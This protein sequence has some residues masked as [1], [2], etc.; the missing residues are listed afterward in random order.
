[1]VLNKQFVKTNIL[2]IL[3]SM[4]AIV[5][6]VLMYLK[7]STLLDTV[8][9]YIFICTSIFVAVL[10]ISKSIKTGSHILLY[11]ALGFS[12]LALGNAYFTLLN[13][14][15][16][17]PDGI[18]VG[19][20]S[21]MCSYL[22]FLSVL[23][24]LK[25]DQKNKLKLFFT[26]VIIVSVIATIAC[27]VAV[28][29]NIVLIMLISI[30]LLDSLCIIVSATLVS[31][32]SAR[33]FALMMLITASLDFI[34]TLVSYNLIVIFISAMSPLLY[35]LLAKALITLKAGEKHA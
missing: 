32:K 1:M 29:T 4:W 34:A 8:N 11:G 14:V 25:S 16:K 9:S 7:T 33:F 10:T 23:M 5:F 22:F 31:N 12:C 6:I 17:I 30:R 3:A 13:F 20:F 35:L 24:G 15:D 18:S 2:P 21:I 27:A 26:V 19:N 28:V